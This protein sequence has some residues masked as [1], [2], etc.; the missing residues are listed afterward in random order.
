M[1]ETLQEYSEMGAAVS[2]PRQECHSCV[3]AATAAGISAFA[4]QGTN[5]HAIFSA[6]DSVQVDHQRSAKHFERRRMWFSSMKPHRMLQHANT[7]SG[8]SPTKGCQSPPMKHRRDFTTAKLA[9]ASL[10]DSENLPHRSIYRSA[11]AQ[12]CFR[13]FW[14]VK[15]LLCWHEC[16]GL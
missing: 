15:D 5:A 7:S 8:T 1:A 2:L 13:N 10:G 14:A 9:W 16:F 12:A 11:S 6:T 3:E 4:F